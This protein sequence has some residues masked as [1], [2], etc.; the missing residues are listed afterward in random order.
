MVPFVHGAVTMACAVAA[1]CFVRSWRQTGDRLFVYFALAFAVLAAHWLAMGILN[2]PDEIRYS[3][4]LP[5]L[6]AF[7]LIIAGIVDKNR[8]GPL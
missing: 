1:L 6:L 5:R 2:V 7:A 8:G 3:L 4:Y